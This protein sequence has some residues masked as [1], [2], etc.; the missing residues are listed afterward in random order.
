MVSVMR[1]KVTILRRY[2]IPSMHNFSINAALTPC[3]IYVSMNILIHISRFTHCQR[4]V[5][6][7]LRPLRCAWS[8]RSTARWL[9][10]PRSLKVCESIT[11]DT[12]STSRVFNQMSI[13]VGNGTLSIRF[14]TESGKIPV[15][16][17][18]RTN[19]LHPRRIF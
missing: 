2:S 19:F 4:S 13:G 8:S 11:A 6:L 18:R 10:K 15:I 3:F 5:P 17:L 1:L 9:R 7:V 16:A 14:A 12:S